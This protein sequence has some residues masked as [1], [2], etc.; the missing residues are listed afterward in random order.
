M[1]FKGKSALVCGAGGGIG[2]STAR[3]D[4]DVDL[5]VDRAHALHAAEDRVEVRRR[6]RR[7]EPL[8]VKAV[9]VGLGDVGPPSHFVDRRHEL[10]SHVL[11][12]RIAAAE[13]LLEG[14]LKVVDVHTHVFS[15][16]GGWPF[17][18]FHIS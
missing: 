8:R 15:R 7:L 10:D 11:S 1:R 4:L 6:C 12:Q 9:P 13:Q 3:G 18:A 2:L 5:P 16:V 14:Q 17:S